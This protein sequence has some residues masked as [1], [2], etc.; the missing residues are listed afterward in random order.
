MLVQRVQP[1][2]RSAFRGREV[3]VFPPPVDES[4]GGETAEGA[5]HADPLDA[6]T[7]RHLQA[8]ERGGTLLMDAPPFEQDPSVQLEQVP[9][10][11]SGHVSPRSSR[12]NPLGTDEPTKF[13]AVPVLR[14]IG[15]R[16]AG[17]AEQ[18]REDVRRSR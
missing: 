13:L 14:F 3:L 12:H 4:E 7:I 11:G 17:Q 15:R 16:G 9:T 2:A 18:R 6:K 10:S 5:V 8:V 1:T